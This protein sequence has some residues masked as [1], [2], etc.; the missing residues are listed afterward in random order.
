MQTLHE[1]MVKRVGTKRAIHFANARTHAIQALESFVYPGHDRTAR[2]IW[3]LAAKEFRA[4]TTPNAVR[5]PSRTHDTQ[6]PK[7]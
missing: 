1:E 7:T 6:P 3:N 2:A 4:A 5:E